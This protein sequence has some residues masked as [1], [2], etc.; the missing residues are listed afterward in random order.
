MAEQ[1]PVA[2]LVSLLELVDG[3]LLWLEHDMRCVV[4]GP[5]TVEDAV[6]RLESAEQRCTGVGC[7][8]VERRALETVG[9]DPAN[10]PIEHF[11]AIVVETKTK[12][13][14][15]WMPCRWKTST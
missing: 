13:P 5:V 8:D 12:L 4:S 9:F 2:P 3:H 1:P 14:L 11:G 6:L 7:E 15:T 10:G